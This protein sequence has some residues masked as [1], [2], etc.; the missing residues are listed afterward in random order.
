M[1]R[2]NERMY[3]RRAAIAV[4]THSADQHQAH[5]AQLLPVEAEAPVLDAHQHQHRAHAL[6]EPVHRHVDER[7]GAVLEL[8]RQRQ[9]QHF[10]RRL[11]D[12][13]ADRGV[14]DA[15]DARRPQRAVEQDDRRRG[16]HADR[17]H[18]QR[19]ADAEHAVDA[20]GQR[21]LD[22]EADQRQVDDQLRRGTRQSRR[23]CPAPLNSATAM[24][25][26]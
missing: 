16:A 3:S 6:R 21:H 8:G 20:A 26:C 9:E 1:L 12:R 15:A 10:A 18:Q 17:Q 24:L 22:D 11:V 14:D 2:R 23:R 4:T 5:V 13:V 7:L 25:T 19:E